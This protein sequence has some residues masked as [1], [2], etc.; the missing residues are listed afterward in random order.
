MEPRNFKPL[1]VVI[2]T[3]FSALFFT[4]KRIRRANKLK[5]IHSKFHDEDKQGL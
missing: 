3:A 2:A 1:L 5:T 4:K